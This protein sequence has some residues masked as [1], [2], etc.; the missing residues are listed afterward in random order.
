VQIPEIHID[1]DAALAPLQAV[2]GS[3]NDYT[4]P[5]PNNFGPGELTRARQTVGDGSQAV[6]ETRSREH[7]NRVVARWLIRRSMQT[8][9]PEAAKTV[10][11]ADPRFEAQIE[12]TSR[13]ALDLR[14]KAE[15][16]V[17]AYL[18]NSELAFETA[19]P[20]T[21]TSVIVKPDEVEQFTNSL[22][23]GYS[24]LAGFEPEFA[25]AIDATGLPWV[26]NPSNGGYSIPLLDKGETRRFFPDFIVW[27]GDLIYALDPKGDHLIH[28]DAG[29]KLLN[30]RDETG[31]ERVIVRLITEGRW[32]SDPI[33]PK[34]GG[35]Y[36]VWRISSAGKLRCTHHATPEQTIEKCLDL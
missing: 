9:Y 5:S 8:L 18:E 31:K 29:R 6:Q 36:S 19:N 28:K 24:D 26:R 7:S 17:D 1:A 2:I 21:V 35:G 22:H 27:K 23:A 11:W 4:T 12:V 32:D 3:I 25:R 10:D 15:K 20:Y 13:A 34:G 14:E 30:I 33:K 16:L